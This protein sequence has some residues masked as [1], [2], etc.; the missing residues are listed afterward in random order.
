[1]YFFKSTGYARW[2][3]GA[4]FS[5]D[6]L[7]KQACLTCSVLAVFRP[8]VP[9]PQAVL[10]DHTSALLY[11]QVKGSLMY[12]WPRAVPTACFESGK[13]VSYW[14]NRL[15]SKILVCWPSS[16]W[17]LQILTFYFYDFILRFRVEYECLVAWYKWLRHVNTSIFNNKW[18][19]CNVRV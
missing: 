5:T 12:R 1:M 9:L 10:S 14:A 13:C 11:P 2:R 3:R 17:W 16:T 15:L 7:H 8:L 19:L 6:W 18:A 4:C